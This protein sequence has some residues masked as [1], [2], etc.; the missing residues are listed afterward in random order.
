MISVCNL[1]H[2]MYL[3]LFYSLIHPIER[4]YYGLMVTVILAENPPWATGDVSI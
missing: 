2:F 3:L 4:L 1:S